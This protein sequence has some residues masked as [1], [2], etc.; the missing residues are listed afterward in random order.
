MNY[1]KKKI[2]ICI[3]FVHK[4][5]NLSDFRADMRCGLIA[6]NVGGGGGGWAPG[7]YR[8]KSSNLYLVNYCY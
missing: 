7:L 6:N 2:P 5:T 4:I 1:F 8:V 3:G